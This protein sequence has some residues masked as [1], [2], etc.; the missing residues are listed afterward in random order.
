MSPA[1]PLKKS[2]QSS[3]RSMAS[4]MEAQAEK[5]ADLLKAMA[6]AQRLRVLCVLLEGERSVGQINEQIVLSQ[7]AL[8]Q[9]LAVLRDQQLVTIRRQAQT[10]IYSVAP[11][12][13]HAIIQTLHAIYCAKADAARICD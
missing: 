8:S 1:H 9:H 3:T 10:V 11:G 12:P 6:N 2:T 13:V 5:V 7:S 4:Q